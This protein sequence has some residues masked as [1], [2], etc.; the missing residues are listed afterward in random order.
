MHNKAYALKLVQEKQNGFNN[1]VLVT[2]NSY[3]EGDIY[4]ISCRCGLDTPPLLSN[5]KFITAESNLSSVMSWDVPTVGAEGGYINPDELVYNIYVPTADGYDVVWI[6]ETTE[7]FYEITVE[8][9]TL[10]GY[11]FYVSA[12]NEVGESNL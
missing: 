11:T 12:Q 5:I 7:P 2:S 6:A 8:D 9:K 3:G 4:E 1:Y 10:Q